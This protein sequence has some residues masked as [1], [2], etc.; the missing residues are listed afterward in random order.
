MKFNVAVLTVLAMTLAGAPLI[1]TAAD[2]GSTPTATSSTHKAKH[3]HHK[4]MSKKSKKSS[5]SGSESSA[6]K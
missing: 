3:M 4:K 6:P 5:S 2:S 1:A